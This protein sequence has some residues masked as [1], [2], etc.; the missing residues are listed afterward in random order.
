MSSVMPG[1]GPYLTGSLSLSKEVAS[2]VITVGLKLPSEELIGH[3]PQQ[4]SMLQRAYL[5]N[6]CTAKA[7]QRQVSGFTIFVFLQ[8]I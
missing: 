7:T 5:S 2:H 6:V 1:V 4:S 8:Q 3:L